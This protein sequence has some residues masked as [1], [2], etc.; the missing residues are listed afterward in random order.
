[1]SELCLLARL[2]GNVFSFIHSC[3]NGLRT[4]Q[5]MSDLIFVFSLKFARHS[6]FGPFLFTLGID[7]NKIFIFGQKKLAQQVGGSK[8]FNRLSCDDFLIE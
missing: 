7:P 6:A 3:L 8:A 4:K 1:M 5:D 2:A